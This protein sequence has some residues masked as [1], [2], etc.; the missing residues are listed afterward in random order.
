[1]IHQVSDNIYKIELPIPFPLKTIN[2]YFIDEAPKTLADAGIKKKVS[3]RRKKEKLTI[4]WRPKCYLDIT[5]DWAQPL[6]E[7]KTL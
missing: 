1:M 4:H 7:E 5:S 3:S 2:G 6:G